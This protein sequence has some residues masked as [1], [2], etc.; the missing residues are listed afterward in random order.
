MRRNGLVT[1]PQRGEVWA[2]GLEP[3][4]GSKIR[5]SQLCVVVSPNETNKLLRTVII[6]P[7]TSTIKNYPTRTVIS[8]WSKQG[9]VVL[10]QILTVD[11][12]RL[13]K[14]MATVTNEEYQSIANILVEMFSI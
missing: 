6:A 11:K 4:V 14:K 8:F 13:V 7:L 12:S 3:T 1:Y 5:E 10:D 9:S 2:I